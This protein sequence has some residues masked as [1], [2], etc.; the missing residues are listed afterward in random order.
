MRDKKRINKI[1]KQ[2]ENI[3]NKYPALRLCQLIGNCFSKHDLYYIADE[4]L[5][6]KLKIAYPK[7]KD[8]K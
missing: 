2:I 6:K 7:D 3:W 1:L 4:E 5:S 8:E